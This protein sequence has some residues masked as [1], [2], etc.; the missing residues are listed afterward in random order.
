MCADIK[1]NLRTTSIGKKKVCVGRF[2]LL[3]NYCTFDIKT[4][5]SKQTKFT[6]GNFLENG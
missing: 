3:R 2:Y 1:K 5:F 4:N 6:N